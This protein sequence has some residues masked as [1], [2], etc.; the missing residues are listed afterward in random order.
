MRVGGR[1][2]IMGGGRKWCS[3]NLDKVYCKFEIY[4]YIIIL[5]LMYLSM[6]YSTL[7]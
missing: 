7:A 4:T 3:F 5:M 2:E 6:I 1:G